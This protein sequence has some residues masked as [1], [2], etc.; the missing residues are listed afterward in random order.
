MPEDDYGCS[1]CHGDEPDCPNCKGGT[2]LPRD[3]GDLA[4]EAYE[5]QV[6]KE[7]LEENN[8]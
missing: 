3:P 5:K 8:A 6:E 4:D 2:K 1:L 7:L